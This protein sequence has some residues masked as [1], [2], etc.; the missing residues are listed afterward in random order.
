MSIEKGPQSP[1]RVFDREKFSE[2]I[3]NSDYWE[4][5][6]EETGKT[7]LDE[8]V[9]DFEKLI[10]DGKTEKMN[11]LASTYHSASGKAEAAKF[12]CEDP[13]ERKMW[14][15]RAAEYRE[16]AA[17]WS[18]EFFKESQED[19][20][21]QPSISQLDIRQSILRRVGG[22]HDEAAMK[23]IEDAFARPE[24][25]KEHEVGLLSVGKL[26]ILLRQGELNE[27]EQETL[28]ESALQSAKQTEE[29][30]REQGKPA[31]QAI[32]IY[33]CLTI[34][35]EMIDGEESPRA[36]EY[37]EKALKLIEES[38]KAENEKFKLKARII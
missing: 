19:E 8:G 27:T 22:A 14:E 2:D 23:C 32:R 6:D 18:D 13:E 5:V 17:E 16:K 21:F 3:W 24:E 20:T 35:T 30:A 15:E 25:I 36:R 34:L 33:R 29:K 10:A 37:E 31:N 9:E 38:G 12:F 1:E 11:G 26:H 7:K 28:L 4:I